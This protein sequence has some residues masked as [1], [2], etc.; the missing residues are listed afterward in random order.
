MSPPF[1]DTDDVWTYIQANIVH[2]VF[3]GETQRFLD[4]TAFDNIT[5]ER[6]IRLVIEDDD[7]LYL[8]AGELDTLVEQVAQK[9]KKLFAT[10]VQGNIPMTCLKLLL[11][12]GLTDADMPLTKDHCPGPSPKRSFVSSF[13]P[14]QALFNTAYFKL[15]DF[16]DLKGLTKPIDY[17]ENKM[18]GKGGFGSVYRVSIHPGHC[19]FTDGNHKQEFAMKVTPQQGTR[20]LPYHQAMADLSH[21]QLVKCLTSFTFASQYYMIYE[22]ASNNLEEFMQAHKD[23]S[24]LSFLSPKDLAQQCAGIVGAISVIHNVRSDSGPSRLDVPK[25]GSQKSGYLHDIKTDNILVFIYGKQ[26]WF[27]LSDFS[28]ARVVDFVASVS[29]LHRQSW[30]TTNKA[31]TPVFRAPEFT[32]EGKTSRPYDIWSLGCV[33]LEVL[34]WYLEGYEALTSFRTS[35]RRLVKPDGIEDEGFYYTDGSGSNTKAHL[36][37]QVTDRLKSV[38]QLCNGSLRIVADAIHEMLEIDRKKRP[39]AEQLVNRFK[40]VGH[41]SLPLSQLSST[42]AS[43]GSQNR[44]RIPPSLAHSSESDPNFGTMFNINVQHPTDE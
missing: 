35:R 19:S 32:T 17:D 15:D 41:P 5:L 42:N 43:N 9:G 16:Q 10:C 24:A 6:T 33:L 22:K 34:V 38:T 14:N 27:R 3:R 30:Q 23:A 39:T 20:E 2:T 12:N 13:I 4:K 44:A 11:E 25:L 37:K 31:S 7:L 29:G 1:V 8:N 36:R 28:C 26:P 21:P 40:V 18:I